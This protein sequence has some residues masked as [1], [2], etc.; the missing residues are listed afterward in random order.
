MNW[1][2]V[3]I[4]H[5]QDHASLRSIEAE[6]THVIVEFSYQL[7]FSS[8]QLQFQIGDLWAKASFDVL[9]NWE[10]SLMQIIASLYDFEGTDIMLYCEF[11]GSVLG[12]RLHLNIFKL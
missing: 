6:R 10:Y 4:I 1:L 5:I 9:F 7:A 3:Q 2:W 12:K 8:F 11:D